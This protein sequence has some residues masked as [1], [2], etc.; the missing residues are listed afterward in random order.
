MDSG[1]TDLLL[2]DARSGIVNTP[3]VMSAVQRAMGKHCVLTYRGVAGFDALDRISMVLADY[4]D[5]N[6][7]ET[8]CIDGTAGWLYDPRHRRAQALP[9]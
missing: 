1:G 3:D 4:E 7:R 8:F 6:G 2:Y 9:K 5:D